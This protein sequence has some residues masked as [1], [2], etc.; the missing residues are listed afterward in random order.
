MPRKKV[1]NKG[2]QVI[3]IVQKALEEEVRESGRLPGMPTL[4]QVRAEAKLKGLLE[5]D[6]EYLYDHW[7][8]NGYKTGKNRV[9]DW[10]AVIRTWK[11]C[12]WFPSQKIVNLPSLT[13]D[14]RRREE[15]RERTRRATDNPS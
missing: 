8:A 4:V 10:R 15:Q 6:A 11:A 2:Q 7:L 1:E 13:K 9:K 12:Q 3:S 5:S 14:E